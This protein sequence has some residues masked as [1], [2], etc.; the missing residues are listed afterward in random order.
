MRLAVIADKF[1]NNKDRFAGFDVLPV[2][3][4]AGLVLPKADKYG[5]SP[6]S[7]DTIE[8]S[9]QEQFGLQDPCCGKD[10]E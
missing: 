1:F 9:L 7:L 3:L 6:D 10:G 5:M 4:N 2:D 8:D